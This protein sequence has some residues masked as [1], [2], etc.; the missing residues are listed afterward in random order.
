MDNLV[1]AEQ[2]IRDLKTRVEKLEHLLGYNECPKD[3]SIQRILK[4][5]EVPNQDQ[6]LLDEEERYEVEYGVKGKASRILGG[7]ILI[8]PSCEHD[9]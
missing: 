1:W 4:E 8:I 3:E 7:G 9:E 5:F 6:D 2:E